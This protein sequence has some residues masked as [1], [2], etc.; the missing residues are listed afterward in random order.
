MNKL[1]QTAATGEDHDDV[2][3][4]FQRLGGHAQSRGYQ[5]FSHDEVPASRAAAPLSAPLTDAAVVPPPVPA[6]ASATA[7]AEPEASSA[8]APEAPAHRP[9]EA[10]REPTPLELMFLRLAKAPVTSQGHSPLSRL[11]ES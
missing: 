10:V 5:D 4:L 11:R 6:D 9:P 3:G 2:A 1:L 8:P 7:G